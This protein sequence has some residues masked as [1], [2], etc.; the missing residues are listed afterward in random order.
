MA[1]PPE[2]VARKPHG[3]PSRFRN[4]AGR[5]VD[6]ASG[7]APPWLLPGPA[8]D[9]TSASAGRARRDRRRLRG[10]SRRLPALVQRTPTAQLAR[11]STTDLPRLTPLWSRQLATALK[12]LRLPVTWTL[13]MASSGPM[14]CPRLRGPPDPSRASARHW[15]SRA[16]TTSRCSGSACTAFA[17]SRLLRELPNQRLPLADARA[18]NAHGDLRP[19][20]VRF[21]ADPL[22]RP[23]WDVS[24]ADH[25]LD[26]SSVG[27]R[28]TLWASWITSRPTSMVGTPGRATFS[29]R[30]PSSAIRVPLNP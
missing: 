5:V 14:S 22:V 1:S 10:R 19:E 29:R 18:A 8:I 7:K 30:H 25:Q 23:E 13:K 27:S 26:C 20:I 15:G 16:H 11:C 3:V 24:T 9:H 28:P 4:Q 6:R 12:H 2:N 21:P 17:R